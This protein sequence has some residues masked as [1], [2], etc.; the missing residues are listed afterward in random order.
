MGQ[1][2]KISRVDGTTVELSNGKQVST[3]D[4]FF[5]QGQ[6]VFL[7]RRDS[8][9]SDKLRRTLR[10]RYDSYSKMGSGLYRLTKDVAVRT[11]VLVPVHIKDKSTGEFHLPTET[12]EFDF[13]SLLGV[14]SPEAALG[15]YTQVDE[16]E[17]EPVKETDYPDTVNP[18]HSYISDDELFGKPKEAE[19]Q[20]ATDLGSDMAEFS[21]QINS[22]EQEDNN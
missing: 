15:K 19:I 17:P 3:N 9:L 2:Y 11:S 18:A 20:P 4:D 10:L 21:H 13:L 6:L 8:V 16:P 22:I 1:V 12:S 5:S 14:E 7:L